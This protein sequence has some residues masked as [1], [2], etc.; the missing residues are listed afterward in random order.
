LLAHPATSNKVATDLNKTLGKLAMWILIAEMLL[1]LGIIIFI[2]W[3][4][5]KARVDHP[6][7]SEE[8][9]DQNTQN[10]STIESKVDDSDSK[11]S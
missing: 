7:K 1:A 2:F 11:K 5:M 6:V 3:W 8:I 9:E 10:Q 4:T